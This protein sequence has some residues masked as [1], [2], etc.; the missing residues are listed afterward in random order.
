ME[1]N[2]KGQVFV[3]HAYY[4]MIKGVSFTRPTMNDLSL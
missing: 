3:I 1:Q 2:A 4:V